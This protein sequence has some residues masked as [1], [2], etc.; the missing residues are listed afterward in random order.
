MSN[1]WAAMVITLLIALLWLRLND[2]IAHRGWVDS[3]LSR[4]IIHIGTGPIFVLCW[5]LFPEVPISRFLAAVV[6]AGISIQFVAVGLGFLQDQAAVSALSR[7]GDRREILKGPLLYGIVFVVL[8]LVYWKTSVIGIIALMMLCG[9]DGL[10]DVIGTRVKSVDLK[11]SNKK[12]LAGSLGMFLGG[13]LFSASVLY[14]FV[15]NGVFNG[16]M[17]VHL[18][19]LVIIALGGALIESLPLNDVDNVTVPLIVVALGYLLY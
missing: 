17:G 15:L 12:T 19:R 13:W 6:P 2:Y 9:G 11:W 5:L 1:P 7:S 16:P 8:T 4:K 3:K 14:I 10:A 18:W